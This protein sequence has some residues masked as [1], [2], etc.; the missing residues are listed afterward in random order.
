MIDKSVNLLT[1]GVSLRES[2]VV[3]MNKAC[4]TETASFA[5]GARCVL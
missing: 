5:E 3:A 2:K 4:V 1:V